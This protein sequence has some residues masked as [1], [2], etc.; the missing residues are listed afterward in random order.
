MKVKNSITENNN[1]LFEKRGKQ[2]FK[3]SGDMKSDHL[4]SGNI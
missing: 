3:N 1:S 4:K 2:Q